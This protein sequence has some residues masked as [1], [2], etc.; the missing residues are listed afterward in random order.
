MK[1]L[2]NLFTLVFP[3]LIFAQ[4]DEI[5]YLLENDWQVGD[6]K[7][8]TQI[9]STTIYN[10]DTVYLA[11]GMKTEYKIKV[12]SIIDT[13]IIV[14][15]QSIQL[16]EAIK[17][18]SD[19]FD[20]DPL[21][22]SIRELMHKL[23]R[24]MASTTIQF[25]VNKNDGL[26][27]EIKNKDQV[28]KLLKETIMFMINDFLDNSKIKFSKKEVNELTAYVND[29][30]VKNIP[31]VYQSMINSY[32]YFFQIYSFP[33]QYNQEYS[34]PTFVSNV[35]ETKEVYELP[36][37]IFIRHKELS[38]TT[39]EIKY[40]YKYDLEAAYQKLILD[41]GKENLVPQNQFDILEQVTTKYDV[42]TDWIFS[43]EEIVRAKIGKITNET[44]TLVF[45]K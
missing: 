40:W 17:I 30:M 42:N 35:D 20:A 38:S 27:Y 34:T 26:A 14:S 6:I 45:L 13:T 15:Y 3:L 24:K 11:S 28:E 16:D 12:L 29:E 44:K 21:Q 31:K 5:Y 19:E 22:S 33:F 4:D 2:I 1:Y 18:R 37:T 43:Q 25:Y 39:Q 32:N 8:I 23:Q 10:N 36:A 7:H 41:A 9:D